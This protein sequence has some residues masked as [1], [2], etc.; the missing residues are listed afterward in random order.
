[1]EAIHKGD[2][3]TV[4]ETPAPKVVLKKIV[5]KAAAKKATKVVVKKA[6]K[7]TTVF[8]ASNTVM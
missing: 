2:F 1:L 4:D 3:K 5:K 8:P 6:A 7:G